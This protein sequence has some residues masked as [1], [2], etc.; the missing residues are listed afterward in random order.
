M[1]LQSCIYLKPYCPF[2]TFS[3]DLKNVTKYLSSTMLSQIVLH[4]N[5]K[6]QIPIVI[7]S[8]YTKSRYSQRDTFQ[9][10]TEMK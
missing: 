9:S 6:V 7:I 8:Q 3:N 1:M 2:L 10:L 5:S 4:Y